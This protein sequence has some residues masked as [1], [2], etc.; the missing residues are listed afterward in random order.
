MLVVGSPQTSRTVDILVRN[1][2]ELDGG[3]PRQCKIDAYGSV[4]GA[5][6][7]KDYELFHHNI[8]GEV[9]RPRTSKI[10]R[11]LGTDR[12]VPSRRGVGSFIS[13]FH[14]Y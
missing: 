5:Q 11:S 3:Q 9:V 1:G 2:V 10:W 6:G 8:S 4:Y 14:V 7:S 13:P 12:S